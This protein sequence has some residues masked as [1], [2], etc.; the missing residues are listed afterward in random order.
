MLQSG[1]LPI[2]FS[3]FRR[4]IWGRGPWAR[5]L[6]LRDAVDEMLYEEIARCRSDPGIGR[7]PDVLA[8]LL[9]IRD[10]DG[11]PLGDRQI[12]DDL[13][14]LLVAGHETVAAGL[15]WAFERVL[16]HPAVLERLKS[17]LASGA[18]DYLGLVVKETLRT[19]P[20]LTSA[21]RELTRPTVVGGYLVPAGATLGVSMTLIHG[22]A[23]LYPDPDAFRPERFEEGAPGP[24]VWFPFGGGVRRCVG[25]AFATQEMTVVIAT[26]VRR[27]VL[28]PVG[29][30][31]RQG[32]RAITSVPARGARVVLERRLREPA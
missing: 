32:R 19:R 23:D 5:F 7:R 1:R 3:A 8:L 18:D 17:E 22:R 25:A 12:R 28:T 16:R 2:L 15:A 20:P 26:I 27:C 24:Y 21:V 31:E 9:Q 13:V 14:T 4:S 11:R 29:G 10:E 6:R 30:P